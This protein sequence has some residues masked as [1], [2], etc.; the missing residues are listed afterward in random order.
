MRRDGIA[1]CSYFGDDIDPLPKWGCGYCDKE[2]AVFINGKGYCDR[3]AEGVP[4]Y[5]QRKKG[6]GNPRLLTEYE[7]YEKYIPEEKERN[8]D[9]W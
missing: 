9:R 3:H 2:P 7:D 6:R 4:K 1:T 8:H 5:K